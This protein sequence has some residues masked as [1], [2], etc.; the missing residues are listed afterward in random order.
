MHNVKANFANNMRIIDNAVKSVDD[1]QFEK[2]IQMS[3]DTLKAGNKIVVS[4]LGKNV[5]ICD[6]FVGTMLSMGLNAG[7]LHTNSAVHGDIGM[8]HSGD[9][10]IILTKSGSTSES[11]YLADLLAD[12]E[13]V[14]IWLLSFKKNSI[15]T[16]KIENKLIVEL[17]HEGD[18][19]NVVPNNS[20]TVN[21]IILQELAIEISRELNLSLEKDFKPNHPGGAI[22]KMLMH[23]NDQGQ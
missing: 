17:E 14:S 6:K 3:V 18:I 21:L 7:F 4:G 11:V 10:V 12:R 5:P 1:K 20:T 22:G 2:L 16:D 8:V 19:W 9:L 15:L 23:L 13:G